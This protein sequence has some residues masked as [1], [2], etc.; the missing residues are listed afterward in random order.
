VVGAGWRR[1]R[2]HAGCCGALSLSLGS[3]RW[4]LTRGWSALLHHR[5]VQP[6]ERAIKC[7][8]CE[9][10]Q[11]VS[12]HAMQKRLGDTAVLVAALDF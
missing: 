3:C 2:V 8:R 6:V 10:V 11:Y 1:R 12:T 4:Q 5:H 7:S 9:Q